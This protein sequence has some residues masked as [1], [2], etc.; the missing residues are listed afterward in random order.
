ML[1]KNIRFPV[2]YQARKLLEEGDLPDPDKEM[3]LKLVGILI[4]SLEK[5]TTPEEWLIESRSLV[6]EIVSSQALLA[7]LKQQ[8]EELDTLKKL[9][10]NLTSSLD[11]PT[12]LNAVVREAMRLVAD[13]RTVHIFLFA[14]GKLEFGASL[15]SDGL[16]N[17]IF[18]EPRK[19]GLTYTVARTGETII[20]E[21]MKSHSLY[22]NTPPDWS[23]SIIGIPLKMGQQVLGVMNVS[24]AKTGA[25]SNTELRLLGLL[26]DQAAVAISN[27]SLH[28]I[29]SKKAYSDTVTGLPNRRQS[30][31]RR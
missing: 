21:D 18:S 6:A 11:L 13:T 25:F 31:A 20:V 8:A 9:S 15:T 17:R 16:Q 1:D 5:F 2:L 23:G 27:A 19:N 3:L 30:A 24:R 22:K 10:L 4:V 26:A 29:I 12:V 28:Q 14:S 7:M